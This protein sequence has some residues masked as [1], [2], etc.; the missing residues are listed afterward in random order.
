MRDAIHWVILLAVVLVAGLGLYRQYAQSRP[1]VEPIAYGI[2]AVDPRF[3]ISTSS[4]LKAA[5]FS[6]G[7]WNKAADKT[8]LVYDE[9][10]PLKI[11]FIYDEREAN[12]KLGAEIARE[13]DAQDIERVSL[14]AL[15]AQFLAD[16]N[17]YNET[18]QQINASG[19]ASKSQA[20]ALDEHRQALSALAATINAKVTSY[21]ASVAAINAK[22]RE[23]NQSAGHTFREGEYVR[24]AAGE[25]ITIFEFI[26]TVQLE[27][28]LA[29][30]F[31]HAI[32]LDHNDDPNAIMYAKNE[33]GNLKPTAADI[34]DLTA[35]CGLTKP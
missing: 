26:G 24:D 25:R 30:E 23:F 16:Q 8:V 32:G 5:E 12:A 19:G 35:L 18:V 3:D 27:R 2:G 4:L 6:A 15:Q 33:S 21:N 31:G 11:N 7:I 17:A 29:H 22:V 10:S 28:V 20:A 14:D 1:C 9:H 34:A 13:Q